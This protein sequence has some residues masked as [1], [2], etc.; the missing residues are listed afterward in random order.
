MNSFDKIARIS[1]GELSYVLDE[2]WPECQKSKPKK[3]P[4]VV[5]FKYLVNSAEIIAVLE[6][7]PYVYS[8]Q[9]NLSFFFIS[10]SKS[11]VEKKI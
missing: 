10:D 6:A 9:N 5:L 7:L 11:F 4:Q 1:S 2:K 3:M 8:Q